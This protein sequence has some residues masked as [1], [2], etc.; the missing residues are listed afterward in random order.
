MW[1]QPTFA[2]NINIPSDLNYIQPIY[3]QV[4]NCGVIGFDTNGKWNEVIYTYN[5]VSGEWMWKVQTGEWA[6]LCWILLVLTQDDGKCFVLPI[7]VHQS[8]IFSQY[9]YFNI[10]LE[11]I[12]H[13][14][15]SRYNHLLT[16]ITEYVISTKSSIC[17][18][19]LVSPLNRPFKV[20][21]TWDFSFFS[22]VS[23]HF[24]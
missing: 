14:P 4:W 23:S 21:M 1:K 12:F 6:L 5:L 15:Q 22:L 18:L 7:V 8:N 11:W 19:S 13:H 17:H 10:P 3:T 16:L 20:T 24:S 9:I 2:K